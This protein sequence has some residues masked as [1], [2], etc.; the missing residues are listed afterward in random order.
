LRIG[1]MV[2]RDG[3]FLRA[4]IQYTSDVGFSAPLITQEMA[5]YLL[6]NHLAAQQAHVN[7]GY[8][9]KAQR[10]KAAIEACLGSRVEACT[11]GRAG[12]YFYLTLK[13]ICTDRQSAFF[14]F[15]ARAT[16]EE[17]VDGTPKNR[18]PRVIY[19]PGEICVHP[20]GA[21]CEQG[22]RQMRIS[23]GFEE[24]ERIEES[25]HHM[26]SAAEYVGD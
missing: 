7:G 4:M 5:S 23:Y 20:K 2:G 16:G 10:T 19:L 15:L 25:L 9:E 21:L 22:R 1:Y 26:Q 13:D 12:F 11:G 3:P 24:I 8:R 17:T 14:R 6:D 18:A